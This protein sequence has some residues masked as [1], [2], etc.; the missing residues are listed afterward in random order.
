MDFSLAS[1]RIVSAEAI[2]AFDEI[3][4]EKVLA[5]VLPLAEAQLSALL[6]RAGID[7]DTLDAA[8]AATVARRTLPLAAHLWLAA[9]WSNLAKNLDQDEG[10]SSKAKHHRQEGERMAR[11]LL[12]EPLSVIGIEDDRPTGNLRYLGTI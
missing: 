5:G 3:T 11:L 1:Q 2:A 4:D 10:F 8:D 6:L 12:A 9:Y 7:M